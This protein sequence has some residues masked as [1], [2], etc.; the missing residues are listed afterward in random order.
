[1][2]DEAGRPE[3]QQAV[4]EAMMALANAFRTLDASGLEAPT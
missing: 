3:D 4:G 1:M 2:T